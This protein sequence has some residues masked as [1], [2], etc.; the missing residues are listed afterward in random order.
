MYL[1]LGYAN[2]YW[3]D[4][5]SNFTKFILDQYNG[6]REKFLGKGFEINEPDS[7]AAD[8]RICIY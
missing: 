1:I 4:T 3:I 5:Y 6:K 2:Y 8:S 7:T